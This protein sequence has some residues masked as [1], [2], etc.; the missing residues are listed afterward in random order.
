MDRRK[1]IGGLGAG[2]LTMGLAG[3]GLK[4]S[5]NG[6]ETETENTLNGSNTENNVSGVPG[7]ST[8]V[9]EQ[10]TTKPGNSVEKEE[11]KGDTPPAS[12]TSPEQ[13]PQPAVKAP[14]ILIAYFSHTGNTRR[15][16]NQIHDKVGGDIFEIKT[17]NPYPQDFDACLEQATRER[18]SKFRPQ[19]QAKVGNMGSYDIVFVGYP[20]WRG[21]MPMALFT[22]L[23][24]HDFG[25]KKIMP[26]CTY[27][28]SGM[29]GVDQIKQICQRSTVKDGLAI[30]SN[31]ILIARSDVTRW[32]QGLGFSS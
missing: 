29:R 12:Q 8:P 6:A 1:F 22:F 18:D 16:A 24:S 25:N 4:I 11:A 26:F 32:L 28:G 23:E 27:Y 14:T 15:I 13:A 3:C 30:Q 9:Q 7:S 2:F 21:T 19:L 31:K 17:V 10:T 20:V 5:E